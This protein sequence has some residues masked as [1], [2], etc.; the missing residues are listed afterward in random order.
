MRAEF[1]AA[2]LA[3]AI[4]VSFLDALPLTSAPKL[5]HLREPAVA[6]QLR[7]WAEVL[8][9]DQDYPTFEQDVLRLGGVFA[10]SRK[11]VLKPFRPFNRYT[12][13]GQAWGFFAWPETYPY[14]IKVE[15]RPRGG[16]WELLYE[17]LN[18]EAQLMN[19]EL[20][21]RRTRFLFVDALRMADPEPIVSRM[22]DWVAPQ[23]LERR[24]DLDEVK[25]YF[26]RA[27]TPKP[28]QAPRKPAEQL[29]TQL[30]SRE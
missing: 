29:Y 18:A 4:F 17:P 22:A 9:R 26:R 24:P 10:N 25:V 13:T 3:A 5:M 19:F 21:Y 27:R 20:R 12:G 6:E 30:R 23:V 1:R 7:H 28:G 16:D 8:G 2:V 15:G 11:G 14:W